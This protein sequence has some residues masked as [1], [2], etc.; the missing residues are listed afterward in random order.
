MLHMKSKLPAVYHSSITL[1]FQC[2]NHILCWAKVRLTDQIDW[3]KTKIAV[4]QLCGAMLIFLC[5]SISK[6]P[7]FTLLCSRKS[8]LIVLP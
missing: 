5:W 8:L 2:K 6:E 3:I 1:C 4:I 7:P